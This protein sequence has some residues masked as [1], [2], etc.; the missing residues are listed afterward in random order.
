MAQELGEAMT[1]PEI[2]EII[3]EAPVTLLPNSPKSHRFDSTS[4][5]DL[6]PLVRLIAMAMVHSTRMNSSG[7]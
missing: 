5:H 4:S 3:D 6:N 7:L 2:Q 1:D